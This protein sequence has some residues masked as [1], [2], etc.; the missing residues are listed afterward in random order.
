MAEKPLTAHLIDESG[1]APEMIVELD[2]ALSFPA[3][4]LRKRA[5]GLRWICGQLLK[6]AGKSGCAPVCHPF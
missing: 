6:N 2:F 4:F 1:R 5:S 3:W